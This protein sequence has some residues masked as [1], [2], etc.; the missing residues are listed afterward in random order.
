MPGQCVKSSSVVAQAKHIDLTYYTWTRHC[1]YSRGIFQTVKLCIKATDTAILLTD[2]ILYI[3]AE[4]ILQ[5]A[6]IKNFSLMIQKK[7]MH[8]GAVVYSLF[9]L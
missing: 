2:G 8:Y 5:C 3:Q 4:K 9:S 7:T 1:Y 6:T